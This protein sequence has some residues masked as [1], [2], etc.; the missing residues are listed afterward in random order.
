[1]HGGRP[2]APDPTRSLES[3]WGRRILVSGATG[4]AL[5]L[6]HLFHESGLEHSLADPLAD[7]AEEGPDAAEPFLRRL[8]IP[9]RAG[10]VMLAA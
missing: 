2:G 4:A 6:F 1:V 9:P 8:R 3:S 7:L 10:I 5:Y